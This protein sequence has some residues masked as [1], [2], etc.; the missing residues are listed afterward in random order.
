[1]KR[2]VRVSLNTDNLNNFGTFI[3]C[4]NKR[5]WFGA[6]F[7]EIHDF[8]TCKYCEKPLVVVLANGKMFYLG[9]SVFEYR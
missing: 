8:G 5:Q 3:T 4:C 2:T 7:L 9:E 1:M 6:D